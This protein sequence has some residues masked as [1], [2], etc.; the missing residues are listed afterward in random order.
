MENRTV[1][2]NCALRLFAA[3]GYD[4]VGVQEIAES[5]GVTK[6]TL[7][8]YFGSKLGLLKTLVETYHDP[9]VQAVEQAAQY[10]GDLPFTLE[11]VGNVFFQ[12]A[13]ENPVY[14][15]LQL[16]L[17]FS[18]RG[19]EAWQV[20]ASW[21]ERQHQQIEELFNAAVQQHGNMRGRQRL[22]AAVFTGLLN[23]CIGLW[24]NGYAELDEE[25]LRNALRQFQHGIYS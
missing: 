18:P 10:N 13:R 25:L 14:C 3:R 16:A 17:Y 23:T 21:N 2:L 20:I 19:S 1:I 5:A 22:Y 4:A 12:F 8:H 9:F 11:K 6:P 7:Y 24:L 15:R